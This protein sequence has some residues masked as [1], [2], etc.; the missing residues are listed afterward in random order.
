MRRDRE[1]EHGSREGSAGREGREV[2]LGA[3]REAGTGGWKGDCRESAKGGR[4]A[5]GGRAESG[6]SEADQEVEGEGAREGEN[7]ERAAHDSMLR[8]HQL[9]SASASGSR[10][11]A[12]ERSS[13]S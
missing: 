11:R 8:A 9:N 10:L 7:R 1:R 5:R 6:E 13:Q 2:R 12:K 4:D 3:R